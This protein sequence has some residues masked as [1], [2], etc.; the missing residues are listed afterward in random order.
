MLDWLKRIFFGDG[1]S[2]CG[3]RVP[4]VLINKRL[5]ALPTMT[6]GHS[7]HLWEEGAAEYLIQHLVPISKKAEIP[8][9]MYAC[10][11]VS[12]RCPECGYHWVQADI[13]LPV[14]DQEKHEQNIWFKNG[15]LDCL[16]RDN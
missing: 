13:F 4:P 11:V 6:V 12:Y 8:A 2:K 15:E 14:R 10:G 3:S 5:F 9:G 16:L 7:T 1:C